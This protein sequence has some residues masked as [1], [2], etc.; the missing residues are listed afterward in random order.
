[1]T[2]SE[3]EIGGASKVHVPYKFHVHTG[4]IM[5]NLARISGFPGDT[6]FWGAEKM[7]PIVLQYLLS[8]MKVTLVTK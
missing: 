6:S 7:R 5:T 4:Q 8:D 2:A 3:N 1:M